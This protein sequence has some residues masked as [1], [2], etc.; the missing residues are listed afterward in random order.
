[1]S[2]RNAVKWIVRNENGAGSLTVRQGEKKK[3]PL[4]GAIFVNNYFSGD[5]MTDFEKANKK[6]HKV[7][8]QWHHPVLTKHGYVP[9]DKEG[10]GFVRSYRYIHPENGIMILCATG[11][12]ADYW[13]SSDGN[14]GYHGSL[15]SYVEG[16]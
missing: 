2:V 11:A 14:H 16:L 13:R 3:F 4:T 6:V 5:I 8:D 10:V 15:K 1:M 9:K 7:E 12:S